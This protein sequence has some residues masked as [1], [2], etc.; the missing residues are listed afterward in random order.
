[1]NPTSTQAPHQPARNDAEYRPG[2]GVMLLNRHGQV[3]VARRI[4][5]KGEAW[6]M[7]QGDI[8]KGES[9]REAAL[10]ELREEIGTNDAEV[11]AESKQWLYYDVPVDLAQNA[12]ARKWRGQRQKWFVMIFKGHDSDID[13]ATKHPEFNAWRWASLEELSALA[14][15]FKRQLY[16]NILG[17]FATIFRD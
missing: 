12:W 13:L 4:D 17:E 16:M 5:V 3:F 15:P 11:I 6:Q 10:R 14:A 7:P 1:M 9:P 8:D 2:V